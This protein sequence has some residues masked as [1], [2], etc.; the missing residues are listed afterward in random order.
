M[1]F[2]CVQSHH[3]W[4]ETYIDCLRFVRFRA[5]CNLC[6]HALTWHP[7]KDA[8]HAC[9]V[10]G[11]SWATFLHFFAD[12]SFAVPECWTENVSGR[13]SSALLAQQPLQPKRCPHTSLTC[14]VLG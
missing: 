3:F 5:H 13:M 8:A 4:G 14:V 2:S 9:V 11:R 7:S 10:H 6:R 12:T 1:L